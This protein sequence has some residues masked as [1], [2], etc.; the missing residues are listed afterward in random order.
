M[1]VTKLVKEMNYNQ[2]IFLLEVESI[3][4]KRIRLKIRYIPLKRSKSLS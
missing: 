1:L 2:Y 3:I 4:K